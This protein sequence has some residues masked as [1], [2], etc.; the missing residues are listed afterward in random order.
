MT[1]VEFFVRPNG[2]LVRILDIEHDGS[3]GYKIT[4]E[5]GHSRW[6]KYR[7][8]VVCPPYIKLVS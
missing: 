2:E 4:L 5:N 8:F 3:T 7:E 6:F 1:D